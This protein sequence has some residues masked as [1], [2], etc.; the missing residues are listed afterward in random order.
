MLVD[1]PMDIQFAE[2]P[3]NLKHY[4]NPKTEQGVS[5]TLLNEFDHMLSL[6]HRPV[7]LVGVEYGLQMQLMS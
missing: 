4:N 7:I 6:S 1:V 5:D 2:M 3:L